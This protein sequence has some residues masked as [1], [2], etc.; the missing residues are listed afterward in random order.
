[1][2]ITPIGPRVLIQP[3]QTKEKTDTGIYLPESAQNK[4]KQGVV[5]QAGTTKEGKDIPLKK[6]DN[7]LYGGYSNE[8]FEIDGKEYIILDYKDVLA[9]VN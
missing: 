5:I 6:G 9:K 2:Q 4:K 7:I 3:Q 8:E 1:M